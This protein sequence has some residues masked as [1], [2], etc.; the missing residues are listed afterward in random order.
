[1][2]Y[3]HQ[4]NGVPFYPE[5]G[6]EELD[7]LLDGDDDYDDDFGE[8][9]SS[10]LAIAGLFPRSYRETPALHV[11][12][13]RWEHVVAPESL[14]DGNLSS[15]NPKSSCDEASADEKQE[16]A[17]SKRPSRRRSR[18]RRRPATAGPANGERGSAPGGD[19]AVSTDPRRLYDD[20]VMGK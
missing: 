1:M 5:Q 19:R 13:A 16:A 2:S 10:E 11:L 17:P 9:N 18:R 20:E 8:N 15:A 6:W 3:Q 12:A 7:E 14:N 4:G